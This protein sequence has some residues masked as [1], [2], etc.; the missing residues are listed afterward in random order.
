[1][2]AAPQTMAYRYRLRLLNRPDKSLEVLTSS[3]LQRSDQVGSRTDH[4]IA[5]HF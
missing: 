1:M 5:K 2:R 4:I 3:E